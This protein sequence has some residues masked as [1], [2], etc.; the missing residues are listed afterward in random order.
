MAKDTYRQNSINLL[1]NICCELI[2][3]LCECTIHLVLGFGLKGL[4][5][6][7]W[8]LVFEAKEEEEEEEEERSLIIDLKG[9]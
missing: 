8:G 4:R 2:N 1:D 7:V 5:L 6:G 9:H 3:S